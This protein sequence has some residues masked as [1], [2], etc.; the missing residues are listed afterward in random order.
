MDRK[1]VNPY[2]PEL[3]LLW[4]EPKVRHAELINRVALN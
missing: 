3:T 2:V 4:N 1:A